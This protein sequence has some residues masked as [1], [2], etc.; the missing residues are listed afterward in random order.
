MEVL[1]KNQ[2][3]R[4]VTHRG[5]K[6]EVDNKARQIILEGK[7]ANKNQDN[8]EKVAKIPLLIKEVAVEVANQ[9]VAS[10]AK[11]IRTATNSSKSSRASLKV[12]TKTI[13]IKQ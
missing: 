3:D 12:T 8:L 7:E 13:L 2:V 11:K 4:Q 5:N 10:M 6:Q 1:H 9:I